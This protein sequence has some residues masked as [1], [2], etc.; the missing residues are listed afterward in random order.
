MLYGN[1]II[2]KE[3]D[4]NP[5]TFIICYIFS[6]YVFNFVFVCDIMKTFQKYFI[7]II[8]T[9][10]KNIKPLNSRGLRTENMLIMLL[11]RENNKRIK[12]K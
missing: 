6:Q 12:I 2:L 3:F 4:I 11:G 1:D 8:S 7:F 5:L 9:T 10:S